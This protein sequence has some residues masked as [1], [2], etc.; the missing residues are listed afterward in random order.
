MNCLKPPE[1]TDDA[2]ATPEGRRTKS[3]REMALKKRNRK[4]FLP[5]KIAAT[6]F[7]RRGYS[8]RVAKAALTVMALLKRVKSSVR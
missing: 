7:R 1:Y 2:K 5:A 8:Q 4:G 3:V 6:R